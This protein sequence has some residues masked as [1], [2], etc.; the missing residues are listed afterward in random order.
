[1]NT[2][3]I[4]PTA[5]SRCCS[6]SGRGTPVLTG[7]GIPQSCPGLGG[8][9]VPQFCPRW[10]Y[11]SLVLAGGGTPGWLGPQNKGTTPHLRLGYL[12]PWDWGNTPPPP[13]P[14][15]RPRISHWV[16]SQKGYGNSG[17]I[18]GWRWGRPPTPGA[19]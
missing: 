7:D 17:S 6:V 4:P 14:W 2:K 1:M 3:G 19:D 9:G 8:R 11:P 18:I 13:H 15:K 16:R 10:G 5:H 12:L